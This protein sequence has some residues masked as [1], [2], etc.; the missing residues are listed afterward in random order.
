M[1]SLPIILAISLGLSGCSA[2]AVKRDNLSVGTRVYNI[3]RALADSLVYPDS[4]TIREIAGEKGIDSF[5]ETPTFSIR[6]DIANKMLITPRLNSEGGFYSNIINFISV[7]Q[8][9][10]TKKIDPQ[11]QQP[12]P[13][14]IQPQK[15]SSG[16][17]FAKAKKHWY[18][19]WR[20][21]FLPAGV[22]IIG[23]Y[24]IAQ[25][26]KDDNKNDNQTNTN[27]NV[28]FVYGGRT[29][30]EP[31]GTGRTEGNVGGERQ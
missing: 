7:E 30:E 2:P 27:E 24:G 18:Q 21:T 26:T 10:S 5:Y 22:G 28:G 9:D 13:K 12:S 4:L 25:L 11:T 20:F 29:D 8:E 31:V 6:E 19:D 3:P 1:R 16:V 17:I 15:P 23:G 14:K